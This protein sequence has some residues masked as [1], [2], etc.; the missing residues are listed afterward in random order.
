[1]PTLFRKNKEKNSPFTQLYCGH[2]NTRVY[3]QY[4]EY[5]LNWQVID[6]LTRHSHFNAVANEI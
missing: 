3:F 1:M 6:K 4:R 5:A 2:E